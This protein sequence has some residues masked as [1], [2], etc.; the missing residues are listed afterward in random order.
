[1]KLFAGIE[2]GGTKFVCAVGNSSG[3][4][5]EKITIPTTTPDETMSHALKY[6]QSIN[7]NTPIS[8]IGI[9]TFGPVDLDKQSSTY[10]FIT[11][12]PK[13]GWG[14]YDIVGATKKALKLPVGFDIDVN[15]SAIG[16]HRWGAA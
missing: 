1:M 10:G 8:A 15:G 3:K 12:P 9:A 16:E 13:P 4:I 14:Y 7:F 11:T 2:A 5:F 6:F